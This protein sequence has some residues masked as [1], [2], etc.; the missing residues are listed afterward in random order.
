MGTIM[1][2]EIF[3][4]SLIWLPPSCTV[5]LKPIVVL[6]HTIQLAMTGARAME[7]VT[8]IISG[9]VTVYLRTSL[10]QFIFTLNTATKT[11]HTGDWSYKRSRHD[12][13]FLMYEKE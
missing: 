1:V 13:S 12:L 4:C 9:H 6:H 10:S 7:M 8:T 3:A 2:M 11:D 5:L